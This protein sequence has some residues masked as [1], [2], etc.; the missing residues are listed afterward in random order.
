MTNGADIVH[1]YLLTFADLAILEA[2]DELEDYQPERE[3]SANL[4]NRQNIEVNNLLGASLGWAWV[5]LMQPARVKQL[6]G[7]YL[8]D[9]WWSL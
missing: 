9:G 1:G 2:L 8:P 4:Y 6:G 5:Y 3:M 7:I